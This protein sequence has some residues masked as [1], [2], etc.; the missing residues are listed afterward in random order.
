MLFE[1]ERAKRAH[2]VG[3]ENIL[4]RPVREN[5]DSDSDQSANEMQVAVAAVMKDFRAGIVGP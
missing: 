4:R 3:G 5:S 1:A 2:C